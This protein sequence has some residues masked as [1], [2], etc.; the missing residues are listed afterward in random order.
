M[1]L[2]REPVTRGGAPCL[3]LTT[4]HSR[5]VSWSTPLGARRS[6][7][8]SPGERCGPYQY[9]PQL[10]VPPIQSRSLCT[11]ESCGSICSGFTHANDTPTTP[12]ATRSRSRGSIFSTRATPICCSNGVDRMV[13]ACALARVLSTPLKRVDPHA[14]K[15]RGPHA[16]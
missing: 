13:R 16:W 6:C 11:A 12:L 2:G 7:H 5:P 10:L 1:D 8:R 14:D 4:V 3:N 9:D 15:K